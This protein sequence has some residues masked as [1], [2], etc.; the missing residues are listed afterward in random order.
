MSNQLPPQYYQQQRQ[1]NSWPWIFLIVAILG[2]FFYLYQ[3]DRIEVKNPGITVENNIKVDTD[4]QVE[5]SLTD[6]D[7]NYEDV[8]NWN[9]ETPSDYGYNYGSDDASGQ[10]QRAVKPQDQPT[11]LPV[12]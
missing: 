1:S 5:Q 2:F 3:T 10:E 11:P 7:Y 8:L 9:H 12:P 4:Q 6:D